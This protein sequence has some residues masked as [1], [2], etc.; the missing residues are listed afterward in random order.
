MAAPI[1]ALQTGD[2]PPPGALACSCLAWVP[3]QAAGRMEVVVSAALP[4]A[5]RGTAGLVSHTRALPCCLPDLPAA[6]GRGDGEG[7]QGS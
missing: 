6:A 4:G 3:A 1:R 7:G 2:Q 5:G